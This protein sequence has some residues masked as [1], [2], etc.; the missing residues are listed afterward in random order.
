MLTIY[1]PEKEYWD[2]KN[3]EF[4][5]IRAQTLQ[6]EHSLISISKWEAKHKKSFLK[7]LADLTYEESID[8][9]KCMT[10]SKGVP[11]NC[12]IGIDNT[13]MRQVNAYIE[14]S[15]T[16]TSFY[17]NPDDSHSKVGGDT[18]T[19][20]LIYYWMITFNIPVEFER[21][22]LN[23]LLTLIRVCILKNQPSKKMSKSQI[24]KRNASLNAQRK[25]RLGTRG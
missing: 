19:S 5:T 8:Y 7:N 6:L 1:I 20:E 23:R 2:D 21:W 16:A 17:Q 3:S 15:M 12:Y 24:A 14:D 18:V 10:I 22:H 11:E 9:I 25:A 13:I 4:V